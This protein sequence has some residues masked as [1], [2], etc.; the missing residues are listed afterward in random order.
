M[1]FN[2]S[3]FRTALKSGARAN[4]FNLSFGALPSGV[5][6]PNVGVLCKGMAI[7]GLTIGQIEVPFRGRRIKLPGDRTF[8]EWTITVIN[9]PTQTIRAGFE[10]WQNFTNQFNFN[11]VNLRTTA[12]DN[13]KT[14]IVVTHLKEDNTT[15]KTYKL[16][17][18]F[19]T[20]VSQ[21]DL[22][23]DTTDA[24]EEFTVTF[25]YSYFV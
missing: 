11:A 14:D 7:P 12:G 8:A 5:A 23:Y 25:Q 17:D 20:D 9:N 4:L 18:A 16:V 2:V 22:S 3:T 24:I 19:V 21:I 10:N 13:Y 6:L 15:S 1:S